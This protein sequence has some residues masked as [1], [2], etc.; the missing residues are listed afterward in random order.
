MTTCNVVSLMTF[1]RSSLPE[2]YF[3]G[4]PS[5]YPQIILFLPHIAMGFP[6]IYPELKKWLFAKMAH[7]CD[8]LT[9]F[10][11]ISMF[12]LVPYVILAHVKT[13]VH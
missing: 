1:A 2:G 11:F 3:S 7:K 9:V 5:A 8:M 13:M 12:P 4:F 10:H 6:D